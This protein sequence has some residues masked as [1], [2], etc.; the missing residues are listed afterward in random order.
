M[1]NFSPGDK[2]AQSLLP[3]RNSQQRG[4]RQFQGTA[5]KT[6]PL[7]N[8]NQPHGHGSLLQISR[9]LVP[10]MSPINNQQQTTLPLAST[11]QRQPDTISLERVRKHRE[12]GTETKDSVIGFI[13]R[14][15]ASAYQF[16]LDDTT[17]CKISSF[18]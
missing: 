16:L 18:W 10:G 3:C 1:E 17:N 14:N 12:G 6:F 4:R 2:K 8:R 13:A 7:T 9:A 5:I 11:G 15:Y